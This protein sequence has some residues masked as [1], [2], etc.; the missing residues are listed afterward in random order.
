MIVALLCRVPI[1]VHAMS[2][3]NGA[4]IAEAEHVLT[5]AVCDAAASE[6]RGGIAGGADTI[7]LNARCT[8][9][10]DN[11]RCS[12]SGGGGVE[13]VSMTAARTPAGTE[14]IAG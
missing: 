4:T 3:A 13:T 6:T 8:S 5:R 14:T 9:V 2:V 1:D 10:G 12:M 11:R 7:A